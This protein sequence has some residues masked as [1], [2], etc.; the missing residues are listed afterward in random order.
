MNC[1]AHRGFAGIAPEN[2]RQAVRTAV[3]LG[4]DGIEIDVRRCGSGELVVIHDETVDRV[5]DGKGHVAD[6]SL[7]VL[8]ALSVLGTGEGVP[9]LDAVLS[10]I[11]ASVTVNVE[12]KTSG[13][14]AEVVA[15]AARYDTSLLVS[16]FEPDHL[17][18][19]TPDDGEDAG[20]PAVDLALVS[21]T[22]TRDTLELATD[23]GCV[24][25]HP[26]WRACSTRA[27]R[28][29]HERS[30]AVNAWTVRSG[31]VA[32]RLTTAGV[33]G[34]IADVPVRVRSPTVSGGSH[35]VGKG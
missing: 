22:L 30:L 24:A 5:T 28:A 6:L 11:P 27:V 1:I 20:S 16:S 8:S 29:A 13:I 32:G 26:H 10:A 23:L 9:T 31:A 35:R 17:R 2:T 21:R 18:E 33:D 7:E 15:A 14:A 25:V 19:C 4:A 34:L 12:L 3:A